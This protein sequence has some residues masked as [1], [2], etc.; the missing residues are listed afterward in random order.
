MIKNMAVGEFLKELNLDIVDI[1][2]VPTLLG[3]DERIEDYYVFFIGGRCTKI[4]LYM[5]MSNLKDSVF[6][7]LDG[8]PFF[9][10]MFI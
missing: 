6:G 5:K 4:R 10:R 9:R 3:R 7:R 1:T 8:F 2:K